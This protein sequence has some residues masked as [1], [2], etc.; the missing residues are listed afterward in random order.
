MYLTA[1]LEWLLCLASCVLRTHQHSTQNRSTSEPPT[2]KLTKER[3]NE[4]RTW[5]HHCCHHQEPSH[6][7][8]KWKGATDLW[9]DHIL[10]HIMINKMPKPKAHCHR[11]AKTTVAKA[12]SAKWLGAGDMSF[13]MRMLSTYLNILYTKADT[14]KH[15]R[16][17]VHMDVEQVWTQQ[18]QCRQNHWWAISS[19]SKI[20]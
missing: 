8:P 17:M 15:L 2:P 6:P 9:T 11:M 12:G 4:Q 16:F 19:C 18:P 10:S 13:Q 20:T 14:F 5:Q 7:N 1:N 3:T